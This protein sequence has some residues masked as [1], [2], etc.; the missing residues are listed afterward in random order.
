MQP[1]NRLQ[2]PILIGCKFL[3]I[4]TSLSS[5][6]YLAASFAVI[7]WASNYIPDFSSVSNN[8]E[9]FSLWTRFQERKMK[10]STHASEA[11]LQKPALK[12]ALFTEERKR[13]VDPVNWAFLAVRAWRCP[14]FTRES[15][16]S[17]ALSRFTVLFGMGRSGTNL[18]WSSGITCWRTVHKNNPSNL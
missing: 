6:C 15:A 18:L 10:T 12:I 13:P 14:T 17:S 11:E 8:F 1:G 3:M 2:T 7:S 16:L 4:L 9:V 5:F